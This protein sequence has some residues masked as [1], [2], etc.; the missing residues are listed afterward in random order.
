[1]SLGNLYERIRCV[2]ASLM[3]HHRFENLRQAT[4]KLFD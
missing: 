4:A 3:M 1:M 2:N